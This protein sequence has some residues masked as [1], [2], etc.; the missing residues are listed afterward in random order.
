LTMIFVFYGWLLF[1]AGSWA[2]IQTLT[3]ALGVWPAPV[4]WPSFLFNLAAFTLPL[5]VVDRDTWLRASADQSAR[6]W[7]SWAHSGLAAAMLLGIVLYWEKA[8]PAF[9]YFQF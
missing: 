2:S 1:R 3:A 7:F 9:I 6:P 8:G 4:W 5:L